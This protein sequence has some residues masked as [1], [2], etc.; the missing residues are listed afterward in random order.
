MEIKSYS[1]E[2]Y[3]VVGGGGN[4]VVYRSKTGKSRSVIR[5][6]NVESYANKTLENWIALQKASIPTLNSME[7]CMLDGKK[8]LLCEDLNSDLTVVYVSPNSVVTD[9]ER[10]KREILKNIIQKKS[11]VH[12]ENQREQDCYANYKFDSI[13][14]LNSFLDNVKIG[15]KYAEENDIY[16]DWDA[17]FFGYDKNKKCVDLSYKIADFDNIIIGSKDDC[18]YDKMVESFKESFNR[19]IQCFMTESNKSIVLEKLESYTW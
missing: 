1:S 7:I 17:Y 13:N 11:D 10:H 3:D 19:F 9:E 14:N 5:K 15:L 6:P 18:L 12:I 8:A 16:I 2:D 4:N